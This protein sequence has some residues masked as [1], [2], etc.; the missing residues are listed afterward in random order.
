M[1]LSSTFRKSKHNANLTQDLVFSKLLSLPHL[2]VRKTKGREP[3]M[4]YSQSFMVTF[5]EY[6]RIMRQK[7]ME[8]EVAEEIR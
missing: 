7:A 8:K 4:D 6:L 5:D 2:L 1:K 3:L